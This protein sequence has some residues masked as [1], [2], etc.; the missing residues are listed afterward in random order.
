MLRPGKRAKEPLEHQLESVPRVLR[1]Q[2][3]NGRLFPEDEL[4]LGDEID[5]DLAIR[6]Q[7]FLKSGPPIANLRVAF[8]EDLTNQGLKRL[9]QS[10]VRDVA[11][12]LVELAGREEAARRNKSL[13]QL[14][15]HRGFA[16]AGITRNK[17]NLRCTSGHDPAE[18][19]EQDVDFALPSVQLFWDEQAV[20]D[21]LRAQWK[22][23]DAALRFPFCQA[24]PQIGFQPRSS[25]V[26][27]LGTLG[28][29][30]HG[31][32]RQRLRD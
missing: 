32:R 24:T 16:D 3:G 31:D 29:E 28:E 6:A 23:V 4:H 15:Y 20:R 18:G 30:L 9:C 13:V 11:L 27:L 14:V 21:V 5:D 10:R 12:V 26:A 22:W 2:V 19:R 8:D 25:P 7:C 17:H 1:R